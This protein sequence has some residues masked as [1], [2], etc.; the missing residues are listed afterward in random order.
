LNILTT[1][2]ASCDASFKVE[3]IENAIAA[4]VGIPANATEEDL[5]FGSIFRGYIEFISRE[6]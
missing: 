6:N 2:K 5:D 4:G 3:M 1:Q